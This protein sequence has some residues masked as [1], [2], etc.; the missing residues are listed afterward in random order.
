MNSTVTLFYGVNL[1][2]RTYRNKMEIHQSQIRKQKTKK[3]QKRTKLKRKKLKFEET[4]PSTGG[5]NGVVADVPAATSAATSATVPIRPGI[6]FEFQLSWLRVGVEKGL[7]A[8]RIRTNVGRLA[9][10]RI[11][12]N[13]V[14]N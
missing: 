13:M 10:R 11:Q 7:S 9:A 5:N 14:I 6:P 2:L 12:L 3:K 8:G 1:H 4:P